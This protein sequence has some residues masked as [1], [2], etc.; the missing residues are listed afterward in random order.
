MEIGGHPAL[1]GQTAVRYSEEYR[2]RQVAR[3]RSMTYE[4]FFELPR[5]VRVDLVAEWET[6]WRIKALQHWEERQR[7]NMEAQRNSRKRK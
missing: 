3:D 1:K 6:D 7:A 4:A 2:D 5:E